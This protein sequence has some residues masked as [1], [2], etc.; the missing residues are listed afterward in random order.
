MQKHKFHTEKH[1]NSVI[2]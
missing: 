1:K 2:C